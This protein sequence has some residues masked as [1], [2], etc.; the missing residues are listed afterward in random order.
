[1]R[2]VLSTWE[3]GVCS[4]LDMTRRRHV[5]TTCSRRSLRNGNTLFSRIFILNQTIPV[6]FY[7]SPTGSP[8]TFPSG[9]HPPGT[10]RMIAPSTCW[11]IRFA[12]TGSSGC[13]SCPQPP[14]R[15]FFG[16]PAGGGRVCPTVPKSTARG[17]RAGR[18][19]PGS[20]ISSATRE[21][22]TNGSV[23]GPSSAIQPGLTRSASR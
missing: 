15:D 10:R 23:P 22:R 13:R 20:F 17:W 4:V 3:T 12:R 2:P 5:K 14:G 16:G 21:E 8:S 9:S 7:R 18:T 19:R 6:H 11:S 1:M